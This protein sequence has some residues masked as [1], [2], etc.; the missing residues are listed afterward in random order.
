MAINK[1]FKVN[2]KTEEKK[3]IFVFTNSKGIRE[4][5]PKWLN[6][7]FKEYLL[8]N[9]IANAILPYW[10]DNVEYEFTITINQL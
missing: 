8:K 1:Q 5:V 7:E 9:T 2:I 10:E 3:S 4:R 6:Q